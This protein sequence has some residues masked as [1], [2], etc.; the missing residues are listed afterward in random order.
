M[1]AQSVMMMFLESINIMMGCAQIF[2]ILKTIPTVRHRHVCLLRANVEG[3]REHRI[4][5]NET[6]PYK[7]QQENIVIQCLTRQPINQQQQRTAQ[8]NCYAPLHN[9]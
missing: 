1:A 6:F 8:Q 3:T 9:I 4:A 7:W 5:R 2:L